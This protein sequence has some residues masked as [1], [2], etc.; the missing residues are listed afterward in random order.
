MDSS[1][2]PHW[3]LNSSFDQQIQQSVEGFSQVALGPGL[4]P[5]AKILRLLSLPIEGW[6][7]QVMGVESIE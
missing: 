7:R 3:L 1:L 6:I 2:F 5:L 4:A